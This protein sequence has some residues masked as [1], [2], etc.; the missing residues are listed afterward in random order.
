MKHPSDTFGLVR[1]SAHINAHNT[2][3]GTLVSMEGNNV[4]PKVLQGAVNRL[5]WRQEI[6]AGYCRQLI[7]K[8]EALGISGPALRNSK[9][10]KTEDS[11]APNITSGPV[12][13]RR[14]EPLPDSKA[15]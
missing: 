5:K 3:V 14:R 9:E 13:R 6:V 11:P 2:N 12:K 4:D 15:S 7:D 1:I 8:I 10:A